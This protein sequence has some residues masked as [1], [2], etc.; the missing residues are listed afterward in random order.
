MSADPEPVDGRGREEPM[1]QRGDE[2]AVFQQHHER[3]VNVIQ[4]D[5]GVSRVTAED[6]ASITWAQFLRYQPERTERLSGWLRVVGRREAIRLERQRQQE[7][8]D[9]RDGAGML[10]EPEDLRDPFKLSELR[11]RLRAGLEHLPKRKREIVALQALGLTY[12]EVAQATGNS[13]RTVDRQLRRAIQRLREFERA[14]DRENERVHPRREMLER[15][16]E[17][18]PPYILHELGRRPPG[19]AGRLAWERAV[20]SIESY[21][22]RWRVRDPDV[23]LGALP[24][25]K[26]AREAHD[27]ARQRIERAQRTIRTGRELGRALER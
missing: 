24:A 16:A 27:A 12:P 1:H 13:P 25:I 9:G 8:M 5:L 21:R 4:R 17:K 2:A 18:P 26:D 20:L 6:A 23:A 14:R 3:L 19:A 22:E 15:R 10:R 7:L 11:T